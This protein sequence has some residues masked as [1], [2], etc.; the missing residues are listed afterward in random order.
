MEISEEQVAVI[1]PSRMYRELAIKCAYWKPL[2]LSLFSSDR[3][4]ICS[5]EVRSS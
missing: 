4:R 2:T 3:A 5:N 1:S